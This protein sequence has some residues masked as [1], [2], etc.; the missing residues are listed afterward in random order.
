MKALMSGCLMFVLFCLTLTASLHAQ[1]SPRAIEVHAKRYAFVP[2][3]ITIKKGE[4]VTLILTTDDVAHS[5]VIKG[6][7][8]NEDIAKGHPAKV[9]ISSDKAGD[10][11][12]QCG[13]FCG[14]GHGS[15][16]FVVHVTEN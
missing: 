15:M 12:G 7:R 1:D 4:Q 16:V 5:L 13:H 9:V 11:T 14:S 6:L 3:E 8:V 2:A 10:F